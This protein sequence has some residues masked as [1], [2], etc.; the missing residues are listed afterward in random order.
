MIKIGIKNSITLYS[1]EKKFGN[2]REK[3]LKW[4]QKTKIS[5]R[6]FFLVHKT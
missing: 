1:V 3:A 5:H 4:T 2:K 6:M